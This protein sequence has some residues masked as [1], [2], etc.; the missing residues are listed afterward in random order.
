M[1][2]FPRRKIDI[3]ALANAVAQGIA[4]NPADY[5]NPPFDAAP[6]TGAIGNILSFQATRQ[7]L[8]A[9]L[10]LVVNQENAEF[11]ALVDLL[12]SILRMAE[13]H[14]LTDPDKLMLIG[15]GK[16]SAA[17]SLVANQPRTLEAIMQGA[18]E[19]FLDWKAPLVDASHGEEAYFRIERQVRDLT[20]NQIVE[21]WGVWNVSVIPSEALLSGL[22]RMKEMSFRVVAVNAAGDSIASNIVTVVL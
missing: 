20:I 22:D 13:G 9:Q 14:H 1:P 10:A 16:A 6:I 3:L 11:D 4:A 17:Q 15:W 18:G 12:K 5:P 19:V 21:D 7:Q 8:E 2:S